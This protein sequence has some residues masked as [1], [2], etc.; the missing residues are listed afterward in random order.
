ML[1]LLKIKKTFWAGSKVF[2]EALNAMKFLDWL[3]KFGPA[4][5]TLGPVEEQ[6]ISAYQVIEMMWN[7]KNIKLILET[8]LISLR[9]PSSNKNKKHCTNKA[10]FMQEGIFLHSNYLPDRFY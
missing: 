1:V 7:R 3:K 5:N 9:A 8:S 10:K 2:E 4:K 6:G